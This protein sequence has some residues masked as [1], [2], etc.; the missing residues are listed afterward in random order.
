MFDI[1]ELT[2]EQKTEKQ[3]SAMRDSL[4]LI[5]ELIGEGAHNDETHSTIERNYE[6]LEIMLGQDHI[7]NSGTDLAEFIE[8]ID[9]G[10]AFVADP[11]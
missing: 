5:N 9:A 6:H 4:Y 10:K 8:V 7:K 2:E 1:P 3:I 11:A